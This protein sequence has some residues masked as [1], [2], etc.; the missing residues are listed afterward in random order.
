MWFDASSVGAMMG[1][2]RRA[3]GPETAVY[4]G[5]VGCGGIDG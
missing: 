4:G 3:D 2:R 1:T 5:E